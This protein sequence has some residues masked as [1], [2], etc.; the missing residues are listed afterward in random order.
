LRRKIIKV[1]FIVEGN[2]YFLNGIGIL[3]G[4]KKVDKLVITVGILQNASLNVLGA[5]RIIVQIVMENAKLVVIL[6]VLTASNIAHSA[7]GI[8]VLSV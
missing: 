4:L 1:F 7:V 6:C 2:Y 3:W 5:V 8:F